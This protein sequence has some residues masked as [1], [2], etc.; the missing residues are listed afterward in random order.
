MNSTPS[1]HLCEADVMA[2]ALR[3][4]GY[5]AFRGEDGGVSFLAVPVDPAVPA[6]EVRTHAHVLIASGE[7]ADRPVG[8][9]DEPWSASLYD[10]DGEFVD[11][12][13]SGEQHLGIQEDAEAC[14][15]AVV[16]HAAWW[17]AGITPT[18]VPGNEQRLVDAVR[19]QGL[20]GYYDH[21]DGVVIGYPSGVPQERALRGEHLVLQVLRGG[22]G[23]QAGLCVT[24]WVPDGG[25]DFH[26]LA[27]VFASCGLP[28]QAEIDRG[29]MAAAEWFSR[30]R[31]NAGEVLLAALA[32]Y[33]ITPAVCDSAFGVP[34]AL[35]VDGDAVWSGAHLSVADRSG[36]TNHVP[37]AHKGW[38][39]FL[40]DS[41][42]EP[43]GDPVFAQP[44]SFGRQDCLEDSAR[45]A[46]F[47]ADYVTAPP[48]A[49]HSC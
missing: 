37:A 26:E 11:V 23:W 25:P 43:V 41:A 36:S 24:A 31:P 48:P 5:P 22:D 21:E 15:Q 42:G 18:P 47:I 34:L 6:D 20:G 45:A 14:A 40:H 4:H 46:A 1:A 28:T 33:G 9:H 2:A 16:T 13:Y 7:H 29:A 3:S 35:D 27:Q 8:Q 12:I 49:S 30:P 39:V 32:D 44:V 38:A 19:R 17:T 10:A